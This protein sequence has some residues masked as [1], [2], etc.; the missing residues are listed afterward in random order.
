MRRPPAPPRPRRRSRTP[1]FRRLEGV[2]Q[3]HQRDRRTR[4][5]GL[6]ARKRTRAIHRHLLE[7]LLEYIGRL[8][9][10]LDPRAPGRRQFERRAVQVR[11]RLQFLEWGWPESK[12]IVLSRL[13]AADDTVSVDSRSEVETLAIS[14][15]ES[16][17]EEAAAAP[18]E[19]ARPPP[20]ACPIAVHSSEPVRPP[21]KARITPSRA[22]YLPQ[23]RS[24]R[25]ALRLLRQRRLP[26][27]RGLSRRSNCGI[28]RS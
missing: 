3:A 7:I 10:F 9:A 14:S 19:P 12:T 5:G 24:L 1:L 25:V 27:L 26:S 17:P 15:D 13:S 28:Q 23:L 16:S 2:L 8:L 6:Q 21:P 11:E 18:S 20:K 4:R 22:A